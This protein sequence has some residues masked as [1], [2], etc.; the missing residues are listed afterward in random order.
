MSS[1]VG[2]GACSARTIIAVS[3][4]DAMGPDADAN[5]PDVPVVPPLRLGLVGLWHFDEGPLATMA[6][7]SSGNG[8]HGT[9]MQVDPAT[10]WVSG[11]R[12]GNAL[13]LEGLGYVQVPWSSS[14]ASIVS[15]MTISAWIYR[16][17]NVNVFGT[18]VS[19]Q[20]GTTVDQYYHLSL[21]VMDGKLN[22]N[23]FVTADG[24]EE[25]PYSPMT[26]SPNT[27][28]HLAGTYDGTQAILY[29]GGEMVATAPLT[30]T[31]PA[32]TTPLI[33]GGNANGTTPVV[34]E[35]FP[36]RIDEIALYNRALDAQEIRQL[37][38]APAF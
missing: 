20:I 27:W 16:D 12:L 25:R 15:G 30:G 17:G 38:S 21:W 23:L 32:D 14:I 26:G 2:G 6:M 13:A 7:D 31:F 10:A 28:T 1:G 36:G 8:N 35:F 34:S 29:V 19:R 11:G 18:A 4:V 24:H 5:A 37:A 33:L 3:P 22:S 9:L